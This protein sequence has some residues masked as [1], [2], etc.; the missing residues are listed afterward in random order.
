MSGVAVLFALER[1]AAPF[2]RRSRSANAT[3]VSVWVTGIGPDAARQGAERVLADRPRLVVMAGFCGALRD[4][5]AV[6]DVLVL[7]DVVDAGGGRW[8]CEGRGTGRLLTAGLIGDP[9]EKRRLGTLHAADVV[10]MESAAVARA[11]AERGVPFAAVRA[12]SDAVDTALPPALVSLLAG[13]SVSPW[14][15]AVAIVKKPS[16]LGEFLRLARD[17]KLAAANLADAMIQFVG[18]SPGMAIPGLTSPTPP[19][20]SRASAAPRSPS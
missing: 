17:T 19:P 8:A 5:L 18:E 15:A 2:R 4:G 12:V 20:D 13:G 14:R 10:D 1:E 16:L 9:V 7:T 11:C 6:G 3:G